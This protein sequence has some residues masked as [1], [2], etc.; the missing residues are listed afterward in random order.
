MPKDCGNLPKCHQNDCTEAGV[1]RAHQHSD[2]E[3]RTEQG[4]SDG[5]YLLGDVSS[6]IYSL[7]QGV[8]NRNPPHGGIIMSQD[9]HTWDRKT[10]ITGSPT[11]S[12]PCR[13]INSVKYVFNVFIGSSQCLSV[14]YWKIQNIGKIQFLVSWSVTSSRK[15]M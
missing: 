14:C 9:M 15:R 8:D 10:Q 4:V 6:V 11:K 1:T 5:Q 13:Q 7:A 12:Q 3:L 2:W